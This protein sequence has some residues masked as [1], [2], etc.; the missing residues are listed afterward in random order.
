MKTVLCTAAVCLCLLAHLLATRR[1]LQTEARL[2]RTTTAKALSDPRTPDGAPTSTAQRFD[3]LHMQLVSLGRR[4]TLLEESLGRASKPL[5]DEALAALR[6]DLEAAA[7]T[8][9]GVQLAVER[10]GGVPAHLAELT[11]Y[12]DRSFAHLGERV[13]GQTV[14]DDLLLSIDWTVRKLEEI[15]GYFTPLYAFLGLVYD[16]ANEDLLADYPSLV[17]RLA[18][19]AADVQALQKSVQEI[20]DRLFTTSVREPGARNP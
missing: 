20:R 12:L 5:P 9:R 13:E 6:A 16:P 2:I 11:T 1:M 3:A 17:V 19:L 18:D 7:A 8:Q 4:L 15:D 10:L 14:P